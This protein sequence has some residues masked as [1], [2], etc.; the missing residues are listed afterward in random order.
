[1]IAPRCHHEARFEIPRRGA[2]NSKSLRLLRGVNRLPQIR[3]KASP[4][5]VVIDKSIPCQLPAHI[6][7]FNCAKL[8]VSRLLDPLVR[9]ILARTLPILY[10][11]RAHHWPLSE[12][13]FGSRHYCS[14]PREASCCSSARLF[15]RSATARGVTTFHG[16]ALAL[17][18]LFGAALP[19]SV[20]CRFSQC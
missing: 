4:Q 6:L 13:Y 17:G 11:N 5:P 9:G 10:E 8:G 12:S 14:F 18:G 1:M 19:I 2:P 15:S 16:P 7:F 20:A 3:L